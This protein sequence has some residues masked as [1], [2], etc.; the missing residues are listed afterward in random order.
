MGGARSWTREE[1]PKSYPTGWHSVSASS[2][3]NDFAF[4][5]SLFL[6]RGVY[7]SQPAGQRTP[8]IMSRQGD[9][10]MPNLILLPLDGSPLA[11]L[12]VPYAERLAQ[13]MQAH[14][15]LV[16]V[17]ATPVP[18]PLVAEAQSYLDQMAS[19]LRDRGL[20]VDTVTPAGTPAEAIVQEAR[21]RSASMIVLA[22]HGRSGIGRWIYGSVADQVLRNAPVP[23]L[24]AAPTGVVDWPAER[25][26]RLLV[27]LDGSLLG[28]AVLEPARELAE[29]LGAEL[30]LLRVVEPLG[31]DMAYYPPLDPAPELEAA[32]IYLDQVAERLRAGG[33]PVSVRVE[34]GQAISII[35]EVA[36]ELAAGLIAMAT[37]GR[38]GIARFVLGSVTTGVLQRAGVPLLLARGAGAP[39]ASVPPRVAE[40]PSQA[41]P[42]NGQEADLSVNDVRLS[43][44]DLDLVRRGLDELLH[45]SGGDPDLARS[46]RTLAERLHGPGSAVAAAQSEERR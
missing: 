5:H 7:V 22:S 42:A 35:A 12:A 8:V 36:A 24:L 33:P 1:A 25:P 9:Q 26:R 37:H 28:Q 44:D 6:T 10:T 38:G 43:L 4:D 18:A 3:D 20:T 15:V 19:R 13:S 11:E 34:F 21:A 45:T 41:R 31:Y 16:R 29:R 32:K 39:I 23:V 17:V 14:L 40:R 46:I 27:P 30:V 2:E